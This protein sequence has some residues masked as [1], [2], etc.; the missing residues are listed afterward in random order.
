MSRAALVAF[1]FKSARKAKG[2]SQTAAAEIICA[3]QP[4][5]ARWE[6]EGN[7]PLVFRKVWEQH[8]LLNPDV[9]NTSKRIDRKSKEHNNDRGSNSGSQGSKRSSKR[10][11][12][13]ENTTEVGQGSIQQS[14]QACQSAVS[15]DSEAGKQS[16]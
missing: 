14:S 9:S 11:R 13:F 15:V 8:W 3:T 6:S 10:A 7:M 5:V 16:A 12:S 1:D 2:L 4:S